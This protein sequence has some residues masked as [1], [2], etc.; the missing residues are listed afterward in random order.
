MK[1]C[2]NC[3][4]QN[5]DNAKFCLNC[6]NKFEITNFESVNN[7]GESNQTELNGSNYYSDAPQVKPFVTTRMSSLDK[8]S[9]IIGIIAISFSTLLCC[10]FPVS[11]LLGPIA[12]ILGIIYFK[13]CPNGKKGMA[14]TGIV[15]GAVALV[16][17]IVFTIIF[18]EVVNTMKEIAY[19]ECQ[20]NPNSDEC[21]SYKENFPQWFQ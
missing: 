10:C 14:I 3:G 19:M 4:K 13:K 5:D 9:M 16:F 7:E 1:Y 18:P 8:V 6:G 20:N 21:L 11:Y 15:L 12:I 17:T 2:P